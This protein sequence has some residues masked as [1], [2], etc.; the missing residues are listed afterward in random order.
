MSPAPAIDTIGDSVSMALI[1][2]GVVAGIGTVG[3]FSAVNPSDIGA[4]EPAPI[5]R[6]NPFGNLE[7]TAITQ[8]PEAKLPMT[9]HQRVYQWPKQG[10]GSVRTQNPSWATVPEEI[11]S[12]QMEWP[13]PVIPTLEMIF[14]E[15]PRVEKTLHTETVIPQRGNAP[16]DYWT[17][18]T[19]TSWVNLPLMQCKVGDSKKF[20]VTGTTYDRLGVTPVEGCRVVAVCP[21]SMQFGAKGYIIAE[22]VSD[23]SGNYS[24]QVTS[25]A[26]QVYAYLPGSPD[27]AGISKNNIVEGTVNIHMRD[28]TQA[29]TPSGGGSGISRGRAVNASN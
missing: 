26:V 7:C 6:F 4:V 15:I 10:T 17:L 9:M 3:T 5:P 18:P 8:A 23:G 1:Q 14:I 16:R 25:R 27:R 12:K 29:D 21:C 22:T 24:I 20:M 2:G 13:V 11:E 19:A 28:P